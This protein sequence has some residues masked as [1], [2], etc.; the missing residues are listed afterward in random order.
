MKSARAAFAA[1]KN[2]I[3]FPERVRRE[4]DERAFLPAALEIVETPPSPIGRAIGATLVVIFCLALIWASV[5]QVDIVASATGEI[6]PSGRVKVIQPLEIGAVRAIDVHDGQSVKA[7]DVLIELDP[8]MTEAEQE[9]IRSDLIAAQ[10]DIARL[11]AEL[12]DS[13][14][15]E[16]AFQ[17][18]PSA[19]PGLIAMER[20]FLLR[21]TEEYRSKLAALDSQRAQK[22]A[23]RDTIVA[24]IDKL[25]ADEPII[26][27]RVDIRKTLTDEKLGSKLTYLETLQQL[28]ENQKDIVV[29]KSRLAEANAAVAAIT[30]ARAQAAA[31]FHRNWFGDLAEAE[32]KAAGLAAISKERKNEPSVSS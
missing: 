2:I 15:P 14:N 23:E 29:Q 12:T 16:N 19:S 26:G 10:L 4:Q 5:G 20:K 9:H 24:L 27:Q 25:E 18:P 8:T 21:Q 11:R 22:A 28:T 1:T 13:A 32:R 17:P 7:G 3:S 6:V 30:A 31:E